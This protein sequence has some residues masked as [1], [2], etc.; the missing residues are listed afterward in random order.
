MR[1]LDIPRDRATLVVLMLIGGA[2]YALL[3]FS[4]GIL[5]AFVLCVLTAPLYD[6]LKRYMSGALATT[7]IIVL[8]LGLVVLPLTWLG[9]ALTGQAQEVFRNAQSSPELAAYARVKIAGTD[10][11]TRVGEASGAMI[12]WTSGKA[13][14][15]A[16]GLASGLLQFAIACLCLAF[17]L[18]GRGDL[19]ERVK[20]LIPFSTEH[21]DELLTHFKGVTLATVIGMSLV[22]GLQGAIIGALFYFVGL[23]NALFWGVAAAITSV[24]PVIGSTAVW[25]PATLFLFFR[26]QPIAAIVMAVGSGGVAGNITSFVS[27]LVFRRYAQLHPLVTLLGVLCGL[28][29]FGL[30]GL[31]L[32]PLLLS[33][34]IRVSEMYGQ[35][36]GVARA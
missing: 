35:E 2:I 21:S 14:D 5:S 22:A 25:L 34:A 18:P 32:G 4:V 6:R 17:L 13:L 20:P 24:I 8:M 19:W 10:L 23:P 16:T 15:L 36:Y 30:L 12:A 29:L 11:G 1:V 33:Y 9:L 26:H 27:P 7:V 31:I 3:P 28:H